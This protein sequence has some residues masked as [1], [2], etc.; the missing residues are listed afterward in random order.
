MKTVTLEQANQD[1][2]GYVNYTLSTHEEV[3]IASKNGAIIMLPQ[4][5]YESM[6]ET[7]RLLGDKKSLKALLDSHTLRDQG[8]E[9]VSYSVEEVFSDL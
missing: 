9:V 3:N 1:L 8:K 7:L 5:D 6:M 2:I 4:D